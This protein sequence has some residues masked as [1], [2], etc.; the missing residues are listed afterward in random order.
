MKIP[1]TVTV[2]EATSFYGLSALTSVVIPPK[3]EVL[4]EET[5]Y[6]CRRLKTVTLPANLKKLDVAAFEACPKLKQMRLPSKNKTYKI[7][8]NCVIAKKN[9]ALIYALPGDPVF[10]IPEGIKSIKKYAFNNCVSQAVHIPAS[11]V[12]I[13]GCAFERPYGQNRYIK[14]VT[15]SADNQAYARDGQCIYNIAKKSLSV[16]MVEESQIARVSSKVEHLDN[17]YSMVN[18]DLNNGNMEIVVLPSALKTV[19][20]PAFGKIGEAH[21]IYFLG[22]TPPEVLN[23]IPH[24]LSLPCY[25]KGLYV[26]ESSLDVYKAWY[27]QHKCYSY[28]KGEWKTF[29]SE[30]ELDF[31]I[32]NQNE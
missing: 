3:V 8:G 17:T 25:L 6:G 18:C 30:D 13:E 31:N 14:D 16:M 11:V 10:Q 32:S 21:N 12:K 19:R 22:E 15:V 4:K 20:V 2:I 27:K 5:F 28:V 7:Q 29:R 9:Q 23:K 24:L 1:D 26:P